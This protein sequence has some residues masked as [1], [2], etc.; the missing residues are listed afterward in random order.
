[1]LLLKE[2][3]LAGPGRIG[4]QVGRSMRRVLVHAASLSRAS[5]GSANLAGGVLEKSCIG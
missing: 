2:A 5:D 4:R 1:M 3:G